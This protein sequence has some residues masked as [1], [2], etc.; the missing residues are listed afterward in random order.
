VGGDEQS[1]D[2]GAQVERGPGAGQA[3]PEAVDT[4]GPTGQARPGPPNGGAGAVAEAEQRNP[5]HAVQQVRTG[6]LCNRK[7]QHRPGGRSE[8][9]VGGNRG[10]IQAERIENG[11][12]LR[13]SGLG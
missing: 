12:G 10:K 1:L 4:A 13:V 2:E 3:H 9:G 5:A 11:A 6:A 8:P 7:R